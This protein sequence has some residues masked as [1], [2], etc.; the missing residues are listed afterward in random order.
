MA[1]NQGEAQCDH[2]CGPSGKWQDNYMY[3]GMS[4]A[5]DS[6]FKHCYVVLGL[7]FFNIIYS[8]WEKMLSHGFFH[9]L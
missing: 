7:K 5:T 9:K 8:L 1:A 2:V 3:Q 4:S 6:V